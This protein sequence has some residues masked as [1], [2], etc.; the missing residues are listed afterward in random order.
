MQVD[1]REMDRIEEIR[2]QNLIALFVRRPLIFVRKLGLKSKLTKP[3]M[4]FSR[5]IKY[6]VLPSIR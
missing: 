3:I 4:E 1:I 5:N 6:M 2:T